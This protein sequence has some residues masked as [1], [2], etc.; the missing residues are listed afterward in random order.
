MPSYGFYI[1]DSFQVSRKLTVDY[2][3]RYEIYPP[4]TRDHWAGERYDPNTDLVYR[5]GYDTGKGQIAPRLSLLV[6]DRVNHSAR[7]VSKFRPDPARPSLID[8]Q[9]RGTTP[10]RRLP[11]SYQRHRR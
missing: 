4:P 8:R 1:R 9:G 6:P 10:D 11:R 3:M 2:G 7:I 5:G